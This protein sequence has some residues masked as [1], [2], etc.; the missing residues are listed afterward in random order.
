MNQKA[1]LLVPEE[2]CKTCKLIIG[3]VYSPLLLMM[4]L[5]IIST[6]L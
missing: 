5:A 6:S 1:K 2:D 3:I 4:L